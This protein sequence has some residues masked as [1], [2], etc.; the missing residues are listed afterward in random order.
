MILSAIIIA[1]ESFYPLSPCVCVCMCYSHADL[2]THEHH[3]TPVDKCKMAQSPTPDVLMYASFSE[4]RK[5][6]GNNLSL[7]HV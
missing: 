6:R 1:N 4:R 2:G 7:L 5:E 3:M